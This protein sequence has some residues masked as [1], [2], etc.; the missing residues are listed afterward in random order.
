MTQTNNE[1][2]TKLI[3]GYEVDLFEGYSKRG[4]KAKAGKAKSIK[5]TYRRRLRRAHKEELRCL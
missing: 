3:N 1:Q 4:F 5:N 2:R